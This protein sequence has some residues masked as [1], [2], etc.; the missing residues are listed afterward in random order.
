MRTVT[1]L[2]WRILL[3]PL[4]EQWFQHLVEFYNRPT[5]NPLMSGRS[6]S[7]IIVIADI[8]QGLYQSARP[9]LGI[10]E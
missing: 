4:K 3:H 5:L 6:E 10:A 7:T 8:D 1:E 9:S 2:W